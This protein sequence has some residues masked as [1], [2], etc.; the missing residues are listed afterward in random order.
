M[1]ANDILM[2]N[3]VAGADIEPYRIVKFD[4]ADGKVIKAAAATDKVLGVSQQTI[5]APSGQRVDV[6]MAGI[7]EVKAGGTI[8]RGDLLTSDA[9]GQAVTA[10]PAAGSN[11]RI[12]GVAL[13]SAVS[14]D[15]FPVMI[16]QCSLQG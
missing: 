11:N 5:T 16:S 6:V 2:K 7:A 13:V 3:F 10:A 8:T 1:Y 4:S 14:G 12:I 9:S 15:V